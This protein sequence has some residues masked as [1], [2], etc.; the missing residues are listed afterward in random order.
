MSAQAIGRLLGTV[1]VKSLIHVSGSLSDS[2]PDPACWSCSNHA[3]AASALAHTHLWRLPCSWKNLFISFN[4][5]PRST[6]VMSR[7]TIPNDHMSEAEL[8][9]TLFATSGAMY[10][11]VKGALISIVVSFPVFDQSRAVPKSVMKIPWPFT[12]IFCGLRSL[13][14]ILCLCK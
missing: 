9:G 8:R 14:R 13:W 6:V 5:R 3:C 2:G 11:S 12:K 4:V 7:K 10:C 1:C